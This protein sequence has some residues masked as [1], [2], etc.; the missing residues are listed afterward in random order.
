MIK[1]IVLSFLIFSFALSASAYSLE[2][3][4]GKEKADILLTKGII[5]LNRLHQETT[6][7]KMTPDS[8]LSKKFTSLWPDSNKKKPTLVEER[9]YL[10]KKETLSSSPETVTIEKSSKLMRSVSK[11]QGMKYYSNGDKKWETLYTEAYCVD[12]PKNKKKIKDNT[13][14]SANGKKVYCLLNDNSLGKTFYRISYHQKEDEV[15]VDFENVTTV[16]FAFITAISE[17]NLR[18]GLDIIDL[19]DSFLVY[20]VVE[21]KFPTLSFIEDRLNKS[22]TARIEAIYNWFIK[23]F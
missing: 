17:G 1:R 19:D 11:M 18:I 2:E 4:V 16:D 9:L 22:F 13:E 23:Q 8:V 5:V 20:A 6:E 12:N 21:A 10:I 3:L 15:S 14:G 7:L